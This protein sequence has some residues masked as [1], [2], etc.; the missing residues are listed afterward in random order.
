MRDSSKTLAGF[1]LFLALISWAQAPVFIRFLREAYEPFSMAFIRYA[2]GAVVLAVVSLVFYRAE[3]LRLLRDPRPVLGI[4]VLNTFQQWTW[5]AGC[6]GASATLAQVINMLSL[7]FV[8]LFSFILFH[9]ERAVI[10]SPLYLIGSVMCLLGAVAVLTKDPATLRPVLDRSSLLLLT[11]AVCWGVYR[12]WSKHIVTTWH[13]IPMFSVLALLTSAGFLMLTFAVGRPADLVTAGPRLTLIALFSGI[14]PIAVAHPSFNHAQKTLGSAFST[15]VGNLTPL[16]TYFL[17]LVVL[18]DESFLLS[19]WVGATVL[20]AG[21]FL[22]IWA[23]R[24][25]HQTI[26]VGDT[27]TPVTVTARN[28]RDPAR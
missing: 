20:I 16:L 28:D 17:A 18:D 23:G 14:M 10:R 4:A 25:A 11:T 5:T 27:L 26:A 13:P 21:A 9:E 3:F 12:V 19:Q 2:S 24:K 22:V 6:Y 7:V 15:S 8:V 1:S